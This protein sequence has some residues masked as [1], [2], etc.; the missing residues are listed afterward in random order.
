MAN[1][2]V[3]SNNQFEGKYIMNKID[4]NQRTAIVTGGAKGIGY[5]ITERLIKSGANVMVWDIDSDRLNETEGLLRTHGKI[6]VETVDVTDLAAISS[7]SKK[8]LEILGKIDILINNAGAVGTLAPVWEQ[9]LENWERML[10]LNLTSAFMCC[11]IIV[12]YMI[13]SGY[14]RIVNI[15]SN[16]G[17]IGIKNNCGYAAAKAGLISLTKSLS[18]ETAKT[19]VLVNCITPGGANTE[20]FDNLSIQY[21]STIE[22][23]ME[24]GRLVEPFE[25]AAL[26]AWLSSEECSFSTGAAFDISG[27]RADY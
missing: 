24:L 9:P 1:T 22:E 14:G 3:N 10:R 6:L 26:A 27:G 20:L 21:R 18:K 5:A 16:G 7:A 15:A 13:E 17:K 12:P 19:G 8:S 25:V 23:G 2:L 4:L 11:Q